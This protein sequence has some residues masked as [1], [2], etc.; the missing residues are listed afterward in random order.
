MWL[1][2]PGSLTHGVAAM[3]APGTVRSLSRSGWALGLPDPGITVVLMGGGDGV[4]GFCAQTL[5]LWSQSD[6]RDT[7]SAVGEAPG[8]GVDVT[9]SLRSPKYGG[10]PFPWGAPGLTIGRQDGPNK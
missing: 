8:D 2:M 5:T 7:N 4:P 3:G 6:G 1:Q 10:E 9:L